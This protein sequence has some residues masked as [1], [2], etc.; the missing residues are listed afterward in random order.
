[1]TSEI[2]TVIGTI[3]R[4]QPSLPGWCT[5]EK[6]TVLASM[7]LS[8]RPAVSLEIGVYGGSSFIPIALAHKAVGCG[9]AIGVEPWMVPVAVEAQTENESREWWAN[10]DME[11]LY[12]DFMDKIKSLEL[13]PFVKIFRM[14]SD[15]APLPNSIGLLHIDGAHSDQA[16]RDV[17][18]FATNVEASGFVVTDDSNWHGG[19]VARAEQRL[20]Q[21]RFKR[22]YALGTGAVFQRQ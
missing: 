3:A 12:R 1:M 11:K 14:K 2:A 10:Q 5:P 15:D 19:G 7:I 6:A 20:E 4:V 18:R 17:V 21:L 9:V 13:E 8:R 16:I 22:L